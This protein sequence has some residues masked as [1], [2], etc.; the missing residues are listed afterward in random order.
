[1][2]SFALS[3][4]D[5]ETELMATHTHRAKLSFSSPMPLCKLTALLFANG[6]SDVFV[7]D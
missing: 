7:G 3:S 1:M 2:P 5:I 4:A 6:G